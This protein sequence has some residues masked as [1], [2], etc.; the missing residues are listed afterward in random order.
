MVHSKSRMSLTEV[1]A[2][3]SPNGKSP[4]V[5]EQS[6]NCTGRL[7]PSDSDSDPSLLLLIGI[8]YGSIPGP[9]AIARSI[10]IQYYPARAAN[11]RKPTRRDPT[12]QGDC[13]DG[14]TT[15]AIGIGC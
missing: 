14:Q 1:E 7:V 9:E 11:S 5:Q 4:T 13:G 6:G 15:V 2:E 12:D 3:L 8:G 10:N